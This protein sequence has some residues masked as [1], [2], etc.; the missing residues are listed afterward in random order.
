M[1]WHNAD[2]KWALFKAKWQNGQGAAEDSSMLQ[3]LNPCLPI[4]CNQS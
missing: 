1:H 2:L 3:D 4:L